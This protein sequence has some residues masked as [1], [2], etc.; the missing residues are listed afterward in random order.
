MMS[1]WKEVWDKKDRVQK[2]ILECMVKS[3]GFDS[4]F[5][6]ENRLDYCETLYSKEASARVYQYSKLDVDPALF[7]IRYS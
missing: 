4:T 5:R 7:C 6:V 1:N 2:Y 3:D